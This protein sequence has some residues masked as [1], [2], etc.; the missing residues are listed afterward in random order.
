[1]NGNV[2]ATERIEIQATGL[3]NGDVSAPK[4]IVQEGAVVNGSIEMGNKAKASQAAAGLAS[5]SSSTSH[6]AGYGGEKKAL[7]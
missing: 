1:V 5:T 3:V 2:I 6:S 4:L 7:P